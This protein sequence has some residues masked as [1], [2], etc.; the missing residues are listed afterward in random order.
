MWIDMEIFLLKCN[1]SDT[2]REI[3]CNI[4]CGI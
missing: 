2:Q 1:N 3:P 4:M